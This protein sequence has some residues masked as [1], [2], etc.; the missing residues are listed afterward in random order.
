MPKEA[1]YSQGFLVY[2]SHEAKVANVQN[3][4]NNHDQAEPHDGDDK[5]GN[6]LRLRLK[7]TH[8]EE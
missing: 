3:G 4:R 8:E 5:T 7:V 6:G 2:R 1:G